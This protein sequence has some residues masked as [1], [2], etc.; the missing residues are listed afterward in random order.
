MQWYWW[1]VV[2]AALVMAVGGVLFWLEGRPRKV[3]KP[4]GL[5]LEQLDLHSNVTGTF[6]WKMSPEG[7]ARMKKYGDGFDPGFAEFHVT[8]FL[9]LMMGAMTAEDPRRKEIQK[10]IIGGMLDE[11]QARMAAEFP[12]RKKKEANDPPAV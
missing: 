9:L 5:K 2:S 11:C 10:A 7:A 1:L 12:A 3:K 4:G 6:T 8:K